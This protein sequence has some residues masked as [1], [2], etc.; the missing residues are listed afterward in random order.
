SSS[1]GPHRYLLPFPTRRSS[2]LDADA[3][4]LRSDVVT[5]LWQLSGSPVLSGQSSFDDVSA[6]APY[7]HAVLWAVDSGI[8]TGASETTF[9]PEDRKSTRLNSS[10]V[11]ISY[12]VFC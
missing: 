12:A 6:D 8:T 10:H 3:P 11:S 1:Y 5:Y 4:C 9:E 7:A 2:D